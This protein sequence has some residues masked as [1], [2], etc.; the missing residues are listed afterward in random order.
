MLWSKTK[1]THISSI[2]V[3]LSMINTIKTTDNNCV[4]GANLEILLT[5]VFNVNYN[6]VIKLSKTHK[7]QVCPD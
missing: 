6:T 3:P 4:P 1:P 2:T 5:L 7:Y